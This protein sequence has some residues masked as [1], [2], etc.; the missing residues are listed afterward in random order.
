MAEQN[1]LAGD[2]A[3][4][5]Q[6]ISDFK[7]HNEKKDRMDKITETMRDLSKSVD[8]TE[9]EMRDEIDARV[10]AS[11]A[12]IC[13]GYDKSIAADRT[14]L[15]EVQGEREKAKMAGVKERIEN[16]TAFLKKENADLKGQ[17]K[18]AFQL[19]QIPMCCNNRFYLALFGTKNAAD[20]IIY[21]A[22]LLMLFTVIPIALYFV[23]YFS[24]WAYII[25]Y[26]VMVLIVCSVYKW[27]YAKTYAPHVE[28]ITA[29]RKTK[30]QIKLNGKKIKKIEKGIRTDKNEEMYGLGEF[31]YKI[32]ELHDDISRI[33]EE[34]AKAL[35]EFERTVKPDII[36]EIEGRKQSQINLM[37]T[38]L[39]KKQEESLKLDE[40]IKKQ[41]IYISA[42]YEAY[43]GKEFMNADKLQ[44]LHSLMKSGVA[45]T[46]SQAIAAYKDR[47]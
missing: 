28:T 39:A 10:K 36:A 18:E 44:E 9:R 11:T 21:M 13:E 14:K 32:N 46:I 22:S 38:E 47:H 5:E 15:K 3:V 24:K 12:S 30:L 43:L 40:L 7:E 33:E 2:I 42:N 6:I 31:D 37:R 1:I 25:Y 4:L 29:A 8:M 19:E 27:I 35:D 23:P 34:K 16:E 17:I 41:R 26:S 20:V 45:D